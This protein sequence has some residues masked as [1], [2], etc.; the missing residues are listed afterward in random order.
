MKLEP[1]TR[2]VEAHQETGPTRISAAPAGGTV[3]I[4]E[5]QAMAMPELNHKARDMGIEN[6]GTMR[7]H[8]VIFHILQKNAER[9]GVFRRRPGDSAR[10]IRL[11]ALAQLQ[12]PAM[13]GRHLRLPV[14]NPPL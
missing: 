11:P 6:F 14:P 3:N 7:K 13:P 2:P 9:A 1:P 10:R 8:E 5:L 12:L 4:A